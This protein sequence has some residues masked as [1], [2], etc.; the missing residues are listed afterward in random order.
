MPAVE[1]RRAVVAVEIERIGGFVQALL[2]LANLVECMGE[3]V[4]ESKCHTHRRLLAQAEE[5]C[6]VVRA[7]IAADNVGV[8][9]LVRVQTTDAIGFPKVGVVER[10]ESR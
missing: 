8:Q 5:S 9:D 4:V 3:R 1:L 10:R 6:V 2:V 7:A